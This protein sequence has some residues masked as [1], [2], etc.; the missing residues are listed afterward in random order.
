MKDKARNGYSME[1]RKIFVGPGVKSEAMTWEVGQNVSLGPAGR[2][3]I[4]HI[5]EIRSEVYVVYVKKGTSILPWK[6]VATMT[7][8]EYSFDL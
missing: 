1:I 5:D 7:T 4:N 2:G 8:V 6:K 3:I